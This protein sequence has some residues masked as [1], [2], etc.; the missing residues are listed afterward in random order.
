MLVIDHEAI[1]LDLRYATPDNLTGC[2]IYTH[3]LA[4][5][6]PEAHAAL[7]RS[8]D[9][10]GVMGYRLVVYDAYRPSIAQWRLWE[11]MPDP[12]FV[13]DPRGAGS[14]HSRGIAID[15]TLADVTGNPLRMGTGFDD[16]CVQSYHGRLDLDPDAQRNRAILLGIMTSAGWEHQSYEW[17]HYNLPDPLGYRKI[18]DA[19]TVARIM[20]I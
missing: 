19:V 4:L 9:L 18:D 7:A 12:K 6:H 16:M 13:A 3:A 10:A 17:W 5:L 2:P 20:Q 11:A 15:L 14:T 8:A 1:D